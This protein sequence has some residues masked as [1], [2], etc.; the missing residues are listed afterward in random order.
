[1]DIRIQDML[2]LIKEDTNSLC[3]CAEMFYKKR[4]KLVH[5]VEEFYRAYRA[6]A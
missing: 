3:K 1:M 5:L 6:L 4:P 2:K